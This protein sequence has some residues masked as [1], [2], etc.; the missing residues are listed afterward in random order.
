MMRAQ[1]IRVQALKAFAEE[2]AIVQLAHDSTR[3]ILYARTE[4]G[5]IQC[6]DLGS[7]GSAMSRVTCLSPSQPTQTCHL[8]FEHMQLPEHYRSEPAHQHCS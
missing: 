2:D 8:I 3:N 6:Y 1:E 4:K 7:D 5:A